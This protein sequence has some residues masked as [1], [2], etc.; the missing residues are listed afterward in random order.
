MSKS[1]LGKLQATSRTQAAA[2]AQRR[3]ILQ[4]ELGCQN[5]LH[6]VR[7]VTQTGTICVTRSEVIV[8]SVRETPV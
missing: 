3:G 2:I 7:G 5:I 4:E 6:R 1:I 8:K